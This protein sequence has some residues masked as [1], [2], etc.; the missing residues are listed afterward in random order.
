MP[1]SFR[2]TVTA[3]TRQTDKRTYARAARP[4]MRPIIHGRIYMYSLNYDQITIFH[5]SNCWKKNSVAITVGLRRFRFVPVFSLG[6]NTGFLQ[7]FS[8]KIP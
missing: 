4:I 3:R 7:V 6:L 1:F 2:D 5:L 8:S